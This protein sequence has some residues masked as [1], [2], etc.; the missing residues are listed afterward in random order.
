M[1]R[2]GQIEIGDKILLDAEWRTVERID[3]PSR[4]QIRVKLARLSMRLFDLR[5]EVAVKQKVK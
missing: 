3:P 2:V 4:G 5:T 1:M